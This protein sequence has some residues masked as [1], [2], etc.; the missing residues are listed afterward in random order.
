MQKIR[1]AVVGAGWISQEAFMPAVPQTDNS[2]MTAIITGNEEAAAKLSN[3]YDIPHRF[4]YDRYDEALQSGLFDAVYIALPNHLHADYTIRALKRGI[5]ALVEKPLASSI[6]ECEAMIA[7]ADESGARLMTAYR[8]HC[9]PGTVEAIR[10]VSSGAIGEPRFFHGIFCDQ[11]GSANHRLKAGAWGGPLPDMGVYCVN[12][13]RHL[14]GTEPVEAVAMGSRGDDPRFREIK[15]IDSAILRFPGGGLASFT[16][17]FNGAAVD[18]YRIVGTEGDLEM[19]PGLRFE[20]PTRMTLRRGKEVTETEFADIDHFGAQTAY[21][22]D[23]ILQGKASESD[24]AEGL[25]DMYA[26]LAIEEAARTGRAQTIT[27]PPRP[28]HPHA[29]MVRMVDRTER[30]LLL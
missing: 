13:A 2:Q 19:R 7:A 11:M 8:L 26:L 12:A 1:Y 22:S 24:G 28:H 29:G 10:L 15:E 30:R 14:F 6:A 4:T 25:A 16:A 17:S 18:T 27:S 21:F 20:T 9:E 23:C 5:H 3:F